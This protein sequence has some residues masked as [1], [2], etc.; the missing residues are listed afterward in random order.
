MTKLESACAAA[1]KESAYADSMKKQAT[2]VKFLNRS[3]YANW[4]KS[5]DDDNA[6][7]AKDLG[8]MRR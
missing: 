8:L 3:Q 6:A 1:T 5:T 2:E 7:L 4:L